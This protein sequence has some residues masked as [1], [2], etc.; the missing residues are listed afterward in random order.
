MLALLADLSWP[1]MRFNGAKII[2]LLIYGVA[3]EF[4]QHFLPYRAASFLDIVADGLGILL[5]LPL[6]LLLR[7]T[8]LLVG[9]SRSRC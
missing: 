6:A 8:G 5:Y 9:N 1:A 4:V 2:L 7:T 3:I